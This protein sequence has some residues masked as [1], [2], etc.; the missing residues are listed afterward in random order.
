MF[1]SYSSL[2]RLRTSL[3]LETHKQNESRLKKIIIF[4]TQ[5]EC[6]SLNLNIFFC[7]F[8]FII[9]QIFFEVPG[10]KYLLIHTTKLQ[11]FPCFVQKS[12][13]PNF[14]GPQKGTSI[15]KTFQMLKDH[16]NPEQCETTP[17]ARLPPIFLREKAR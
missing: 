16:A 8:P 4:Y 17:C 2:A 13:S 1:T 15:S 12:F 14:P 9:H 5:V 11:N 7:I 10:S 3:Y 6:S